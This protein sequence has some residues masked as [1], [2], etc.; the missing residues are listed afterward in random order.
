MNR[1]QGTPVEAIWLACTTAVTVVATVFHVI[2]SWLEYWVICEFDGQNGKPYWDVYLSGYV[3][4]LNSGLWRTCFAYAAMSE[5]ATNNVGNSSFAALS[6]AEQSTTIARS[7]S[8]E[9]CR[10][11]LSILLILRN[12]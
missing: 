8:F 7:T 9:I 2:I 12:F 1:Y 11:S 10:R 5:E 6:I 3:C 4:T